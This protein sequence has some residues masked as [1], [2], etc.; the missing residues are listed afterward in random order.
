M[1]YKMTIVS[2]I[3]KKCLKPLTTMDELRLELCIKCD[4]MQLEGREARHESQVSERPEER[5]QDPE[6]SY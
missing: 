3:C 1:T 4:E 5:V 2:L 6:D